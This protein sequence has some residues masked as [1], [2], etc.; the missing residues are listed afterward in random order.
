[1][2]K[3]LAILGKQLYITYTDRNLLLIMLATPMALATIFALVFG[4][5]DGINVRDISVV[6]VN[7]DSANNT[8]ATF[9]SGQIFVD[10]L[11]PESEQI[12]SE[13]T[14]TPAS[15]ATPE[16]TSNFAVAIPDDTSG[17]TCASAP[18]DSNNAV[19]VTLFDLT[20]AVQ[21]NDVEAARAGVDNGDY[22]AAVIIPPDFSEKVAYSPDHPQI[23]QATIEVYASSGSQITGGIVRSIV[24]SIA[25]QIATGNITIAATIDTL[26]SR[27]QADP[28]FGFNFA[29]AANQGEFQPNF[30]CAFTP[31]FNPVQVESQTVTGERVEFNP[32]VSFGSG[33]SIFFMLFTA[34]GA[35]NAML[36]E[37]HTGTLQRM[38]VTPTSR[39]QILIGQ[40]GAAFVSSLVQIMLLFLALTLI[41]TLINGELTLVW[42]NNIPLIILVLISASLSV[43]GLGTLLASIASTPEA[44]NTAGSAINIVLGLLGGAFFPVQNI[45]EIRPFTV[46]SP[47]FW[48]T[49]AFTKLS[50]NIP[51][52]GLN[53]VILLA[54]GLVMFLIGLWLFNRRLDV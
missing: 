36:E 6:I 46:V 14:S 48:G 8:D 7:L 1:M 45:P 32:L 42:G 9:D 16:S 4:G 40:L 25:D 52:V 10:I 33:I 41:G 37:Q 13:A 17:L 19:G 2:S 43:A 15:E 27:A 34:Q 31:A 50:Q 5:T 38:L 29:R 53:I 23:E 12:V 11:V 28:L 49:D 26:V 30:A 39:L 54:Q 3:I 35:A 44:A 51:D 20:D 21:L 24:Q 18:T 22:V 47:V